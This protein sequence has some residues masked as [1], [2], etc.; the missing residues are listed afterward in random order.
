MFRRDFVR[1]VIAGACGLFVPLG[2]I[3]ATDTS[4]PF[5]HLLKGTNFTC[6]PVYYISKDP[7]TPKIKF[8][9][10]SLYYDTSKKFVM[11]KGLRLM[12]SRFNSSLPYLLWDSVG[13]MLKHEAADDKLLEVWRS[14]VTARRL[15]IKNGV[16]FE[17][18]ENED[19]TLC[20]LRSRGFHDYWIRSYA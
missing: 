3:W 13:D 1:T 19:G 17:A 18:F 15:D 11:P 6:G 4:D 12:R 16:K 8:T 10:M 14:D 7:R 2:K 9:V 5:S 20:F